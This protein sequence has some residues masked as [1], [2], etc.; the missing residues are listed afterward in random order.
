[1]DSHSMKYVKDYTF[2]DHCAEGLGAISPEEGEDIV[3]VPAGYDEVGS[4]AYVVHI[5]NRVEYRIV[6]F[7]DIST[8][9]FMGE[10]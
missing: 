3:Y 6:N 9:D 5:R 7:I 2:I 4:P 1:M 8:I 10:E